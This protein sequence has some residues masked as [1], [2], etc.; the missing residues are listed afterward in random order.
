MREHMASWSKQVHND[1]QTMCAPSPSP[2]FVPLHH[3]TR[4]LAEAKARGRSLGV[5]LT[6]EP[7]QVLTVLQLSNNPFYCCLDIPLVCG[8]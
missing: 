7:H 2:S 6:V 5:Q 1:Q 8:R 3:R 4:T